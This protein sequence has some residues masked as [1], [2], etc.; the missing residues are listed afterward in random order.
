MVY[1]TFEKKIFDFFFIFFSN[2]F[3]KYLLRRFFE[4]YICF[5]GCICYEDSE[6]VWFNELFFKKNF[7]IFFIFFPEIFQEIFVETFFRV[8]YMFS[9][10]Y[11]L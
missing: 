3:E 1:W 9:E 8:V 10:M 2:F 5:L 6:N 7:L 11:L 4:L